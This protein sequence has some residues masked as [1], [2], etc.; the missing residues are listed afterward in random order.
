M[1]QVRLVY[2]DEEENI[3]NFDDIFRDDE[4]EVSNNTLNI[5]NCQFLAASQLS[6][7]CNL[8]IYR[9]SIYSSLSPVDL[10]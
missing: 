7:L 2:K 3:P 5:P 4:D 1:L 8:W 9:K 6:G 10:M